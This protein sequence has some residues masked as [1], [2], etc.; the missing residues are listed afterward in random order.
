MVSIVSDSA[1]SAKGGQRPQSDRSSVVSFALRLLTFVQ[2]SVWV[3]RRAEPGERVIERLRYGR[4]ACIGRSLLKM[5]AATF[6]PPFT[7][8]QTTTYL[9]RSSTGPDAPRVVSR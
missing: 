6:H 2:K 8:R 1:A 5:S 3:R 9:P 7:L 4:R